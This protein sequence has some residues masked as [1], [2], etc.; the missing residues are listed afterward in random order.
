M[1][2]GVNAEDLAMLFFKQQIALVA[3]WLFDVL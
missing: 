3:L 1:V 2:Q